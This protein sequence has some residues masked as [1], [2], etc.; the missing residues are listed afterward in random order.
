MKFIL[1]LFLLVLI[2]ITILF[3]MTYWTNEW[4]ANQ[5]IFV[6]GKAPNPS[7]DGFYSG[8]AYLTGS[9]LG[10]KFDARY[11][12]GINV[13]KDLGNAEVE[14]Y[15]FKTFFG[16]GIRDT[17]L[18]VMKIDYDIPENPF[19]IRPILDEI[20]ETAPGEYMGKLH[21]RIIPGFSFSPL[22]FFLEKPL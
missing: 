13:F 9:W 20:V 8:S 19:W 18:Q 3:C 16:P 12:E 15:P 22:Y 21:L 10:K 11:E 17:H 5:K 4:S 14:K 1:I 2:A 7:P 6:S